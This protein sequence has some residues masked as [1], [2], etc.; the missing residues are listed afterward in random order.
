M[1]Q[2]DFLGHESLSLKFLQSVSLFLRPLLTG[3]AFLHESLAGCLRPDCVD[4]APE[5]LNVG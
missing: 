5:N 2:E 1:P 3:G 4:S